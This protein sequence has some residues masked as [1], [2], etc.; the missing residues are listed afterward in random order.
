MAIECH[1]LRKKHTATAAVDPSQLLDVFDTFGGLVL[2]IPTGSAKNVPKQFKKIPPTGIEP[3]T[4]ALGKRR[5][6]IAPQRLALSYCCGFSDWSLLRVI[7]S[8][9]STF[10]SFHP[11]CQEKRSVQAPLAYALCKMPIG[12]SP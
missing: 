9:K 6:T 5:A 2:L 1:A 12:R 3:A 10:F 7:N 11:P 4:F 8:P